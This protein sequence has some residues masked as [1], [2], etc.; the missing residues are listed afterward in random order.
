MTG[1]SRGFGFVRYSDRAVQV[2]VF[3]SSHT[4]KGRRVELKYPKQQVGLGLGLVTLLRG[5]RWS[6]A[7]SKPL[8]MFGHTFKSIPYVHSC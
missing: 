2:S 8:K 3:E 6:S 1:K 4:I 5:G 7:H